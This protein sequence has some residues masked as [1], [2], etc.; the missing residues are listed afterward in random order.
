MSLLLWSQSFSVSLPLNLPWT[1]LCGIPFANRLMPSCYSVILGSS[2]VSPHLALQANSE[3]STRAQPS[4]SAKEGRYIERL[5]SQLVGQ[6]SW[7]GPI[8]AFVCERILPPSYM[9]GITRGQAHT[10]FR[11]DGMKRSASADPSFLLSP[12]ASPQNINYSLCRISQE[13]PLTLMPK[14]TSLSQL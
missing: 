14:P 10:M 12:H 8:F 6:L 11:R 1:H 9:K 5:G 7:G 2:G 4:L 3:R 13:D